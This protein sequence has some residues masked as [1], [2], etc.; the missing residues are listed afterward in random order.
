MG[1]AAPNGIR[2][3]RAA[4]RNLSTVMCW[5]ASEKTSVM[6]CIDDQDGKAMGGDA[7]EKLMEIELFDEFQAGCWPAGS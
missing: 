6:S 3:P 5:A 4:P 2:R 1:G 7:L